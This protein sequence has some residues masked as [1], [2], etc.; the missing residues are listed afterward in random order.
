MLTAIVFDALFYRYFN[1]FTYLAGT[2]AYLWN[3][4]DARWNKVARSKEYSCAT[5]A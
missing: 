5:E 1:L 4:R 3:S 2:V